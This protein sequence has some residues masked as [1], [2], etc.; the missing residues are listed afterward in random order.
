MILLLLPFKYWDCQCV[1]QASE[2]V[3]RLET[4]GLALQRT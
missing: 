4:L 2:T 3:Q 1:P